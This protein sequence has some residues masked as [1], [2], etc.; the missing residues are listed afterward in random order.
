MTCFT[1]LSAQRSKKGHAAKW[2]DWSVWSECSV[3]CGTG[4]ESQTR[5]CVTSAQNTSVGC[6][7]KRERFRHC[8]RHACQI[9][10]ISLFNNEQQVH[11]SDVTTT[12]P[13]SVELSY[14]GEPHLDTAKWG[15]SSI[16]DSPLCCGCQC[17]ASPT[18]QSMFNANINFSFM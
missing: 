16:F 15:S 4:R 18:G 10:E 11:S 5:R 14:M 12:V 13:L 8:V 17:L 6:E 7:G 9:G 1:G 3:T 2:T